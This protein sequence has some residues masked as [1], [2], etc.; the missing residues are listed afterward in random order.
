M[1]IEIPAITNPGVSFTENSYEIIRGVHEF[2]HDTN[3][4]RISYKDF[5]KA[6]MRVDPKGDSKIRMLFPLLRKAGCIY[7][8]DDGNVVFHNGSFFTQ[9]GESFFKISSLYYQAK[10]RAKSIPKNEANTAAAIILKAR[11]I[12]SKVAMTLFRNLCEQEDV[13]RHLL[14]FVVQYGPVSKDEIQIL[15]YS[16]AKTS[17]N[18]GSVVSCTYDTKEISDLMDKFRRGTLK[19]VSKKD[20]NAAGYFIAILKTLLVVDENHGSYVVSEEFK[21]NSKGV[22]Q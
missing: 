6:Y 15:L 14:Q 19:C 5:Q 7:P 3:V 16:L 22:K 9:L 18:P 11:G 1:T 13:Y 12:Y 2:F 4:T 21:V 17:S 8:D 20:N 10:R